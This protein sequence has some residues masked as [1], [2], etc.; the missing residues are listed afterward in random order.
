MIKKGL[1]SGI[2]PII[3]IFFGISHILPFFTTTALMIL[4]K[5][6]Y[7]SSQFYGSILYFS[8]LSPTFAALILLHFFYSKKEKINYLHR[9]INM[10]YITYKEYLLIFGLPFFIRIFAAIFE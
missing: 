1:Y 8:L 4:E 7:I 9:I 6:I 10:D 5:N 3:V 2:K